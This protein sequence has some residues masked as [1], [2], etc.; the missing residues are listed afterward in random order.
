[1]YQH[2]SI[3]AF[4]SLH[5]ACA[6]DGADILLTTDTKFIRAA[7]KL[8]TEIRVCNPIDFLMEVNEDEHD[9]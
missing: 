5:L 3:K 8:D 9:N 7:G 6:E 1:M 2:S 4:D